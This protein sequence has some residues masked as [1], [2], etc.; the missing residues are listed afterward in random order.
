MRITI[1]KL[2]QFKK[3]ANTHREA[4]YERFVEAHEIINNQNT[5]EIK[6]IAEYNFWGG[7]E[8]AFLKIEQYRR[9]NPPDESNQHII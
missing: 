5:S 1:K 3:M 7:Y 9:L 6:V 8:Y 2:H 4:L